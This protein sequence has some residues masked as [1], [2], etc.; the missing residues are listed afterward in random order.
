M[1]WG[2]RVTATAGLILW[3]ATSF[4]KDAPGPRLIAEDAGFAIHQFRGSVDFGWEAPIRLGVVIS[5][6]DLRTG[7][8]R[9][10]VA[11][12]AH[13]VNTRRISYSITRLLGLAQ[14]DTHVL[15]V[16]FHSG[17]IFTEDDRFP[18]D[19][20]AVDGLYKLRVF[21][22]QTGRQTGTWRFGPPEVLPRRVPAETTDAGVIARCA[23][24]YRMFGGIFRIDG[25]GAV[26]RA[27]KGPAQDGSAQSQ[28]PRPPRRAAGPVLRGNALAPRCTR[29]T[30]RFDTHAGTAG[31]PTGV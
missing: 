12:G 25:T 24:G 17:R 9:W 10:L 23:E 1:Q 19:P 4:A 7:A 30:R 28:Q 20:D 29:A 8:M 26:R 22:E 16:V 31:T 2:R 18:G 13:A 5:H 11:T 15:A 14:D 27:G 21:S 3:W 6:T